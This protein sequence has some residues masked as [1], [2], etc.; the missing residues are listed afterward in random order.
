MQSTA[1]T[2][3][4][5]FY[6]D[7]FNGSPMQ[8][9]KPLLLAT[10]LGCLIFLFIGTYYYLRRQGNLAQ[11][12][13]LLCEV[14]KPGMSKNQ[15]LDILK[16]SGDVVVNGAES[17]SPNVE[18]NVVF[19]DPKGQEIYGAFEIGFS[20]YKYESAYIRDMDTWNVICDFSQ[21]TQ[22]G[23]GTSMP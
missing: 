7:K 8:N 4:G 23:I 12:H 17:P 18:W 3:L 14:L 10:L 6:N 22:E 21:P 5:F 16:Q 13:Y 15:V 2:R 11:R 20:D 1:T 9:R 19:T